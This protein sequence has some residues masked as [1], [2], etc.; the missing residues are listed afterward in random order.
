VFNATGNLP[1]R[2]TFSDSVPRGVAVVHKGRWP[3]LDPS[4]ANVNVLNPGAKTD[5]GQS[6]S[7][8]SIEVDVRLA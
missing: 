1:S 5:V 8:H 3:K 6:S 2:V 4:R 7:V